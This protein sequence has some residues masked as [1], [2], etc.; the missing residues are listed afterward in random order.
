MTLLLDPRKG[1][2]EDDTSSTKGRSLLSLAGTLLVEISL[3]KLVAA[4]LLLGALPAFLLGLSPLVGSA[5]L[6]T[7]SRSMGSAYGGLLTFALIL[8]VLAVGWFGGRKIFRIAEQAFWALNAMAVQP[9]YALYREAI[10][11]FA[12]LALG[13]WL[14]EQRRARLRAFSAAAAGIFLCA[15]SLLIVWLIGPY[16]R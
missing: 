13:R 16:T 2:I 10:R 14:D 8:A 1:D 9:F 4:W 11:H 15:L 7:F 3:P 5:W 12:E 6:T